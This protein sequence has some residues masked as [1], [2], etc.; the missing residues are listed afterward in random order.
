MFLMPRALPSLV[1]EVSGRSSGLG[2]LSFPVPSPHLKINDSQGSGSPGVITIKISLDYSGQS[3]FFGCWFWIFVRQG[4][5][6]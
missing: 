2:P 6:E 4:L 3:S 5:Q 1:A